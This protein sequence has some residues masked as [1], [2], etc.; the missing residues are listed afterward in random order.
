MAKEKC[1]RIKTIKHLN[2][3]ENKLAKEI[4]HSY[5]TEGKS[6]LLWQYL[7][8]YILFNTNRNEN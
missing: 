6:I 5:F 8:I 4:F 2:P 1:P 3:S 7:Y